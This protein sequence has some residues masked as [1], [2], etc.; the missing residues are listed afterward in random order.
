MRP[1]QFHS[2]DVTPTKGDEMTWEETAKKIDEEAMALAQKSLNRISYEDAAKELGVKEKTIY[3]YISKGRLKS[4]KKGYVTRES[5]EK[6]KAKRTKNLEA[7]K[8]KEIK[9]TNETTA[10]QIKPIDEATKEDSADTEYIVT[11]GELKE[12]LNTAMKLGYEKGK[13]E[14]K[15]EKIDL[16][17]MLNLIAS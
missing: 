14:C 15:R 9:Q 13:S 1:I 4:D 11:K 2:Y 10:K 6:Y 17:G 7:I 8:Q 16:K 5:V 12:A 3:D